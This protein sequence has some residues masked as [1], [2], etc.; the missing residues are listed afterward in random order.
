[1]DR[2]F[3]ALSMD[4]ED[5]YHLDCLQS[6]NPDTSKS[7][8]DG[9]VNY[10]EMLNGHGIKATFFVLGELA[11]QARETLL[12]LDG[13]GHEIACHGMHH[14][15]PTSLSPAAFAEQLRCA[16]QT[17]EDL[18]GK[19]VTGYRAPQNALDDE[20]LAIVQKIG[21][22]YDASWLDAPEH[23]ISRRLH[24]SGWE[25]PLPGTRWRDGF[26]ELPLCGSTLLGRPLCISGGG[27]MHVLPWH[28]VMKPLIAA[29]LREARVYTLCA[30]PFEF[31]DRAMPSLSGVSLQTRLRVLK[32]PGAMERRVEQ[33]IDMLE[34]HAFEFATFEDLS[35][36]LRREARP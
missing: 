14:T 33:L 9:F 1:M 27:W 22:H 24:F 23:P 3:A 36:Q 20:R 13:C 26:C 30:Y 29:Y 6:C 21:F 16:K 2:K 12:Y 31:S 28:G 8:L 10:A 7:M 5:W 15:P 17:L 4:V 19:E 34:H 35:H 25:E 32:S 11:Q 18:L